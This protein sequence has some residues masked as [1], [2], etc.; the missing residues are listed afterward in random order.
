MKYS[1]ACIKKYLIFFIQVSKLA[2]IS[3]YFIKTLKYVS[4]EQEVTFCVCF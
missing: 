1:G 3:P 4:S 2:S